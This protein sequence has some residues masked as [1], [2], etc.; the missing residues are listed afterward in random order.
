MQADSTKQ[1]TPPGAPLARGG[2]VGTRLRHYVYWTILLTALGQIVAILASWLITAAI[3]EKPFRSLLSV[4]GLRWFFGNFTANMQ[5]PWLV[6]LVLLVIAGGCIYGSGLWHSLRAL[7]SARRSVITSQQSFALKGCALLLALEVTAMLLL[8]V[9][10][11]AVLV[12]ITGEV[13]PRA[14]SSAFLPTL[15]FMGTSVGLVFG[16][17]SGRVRS[18]YDAGQCLCHGGPWLLPLLAL[19]LSAMLFVHCVMYVFGL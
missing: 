16:L 11:H 19:Y 5:S 13:F 14:F 1:T 10:S 7:L 12:S 8:T 9:P 3:P 17:L 4:S 6:Y 15:A 2:G 18:V